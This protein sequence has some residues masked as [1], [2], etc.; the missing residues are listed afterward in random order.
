M[1][2]SEIA[3]LQSEGNLYRF[4][5]HHTLLHDYNYS[6]NMK[7]IFT[8]CLLLTACNLHAQSINDYFQKIRN[9]AA[10]LTAFISQMPKGGDLHNHYS[11]AIYAESYLARVIDKDYCI[12]PQTLEIAPPS[13][14]G[15]CNQGWTKF[16]ILKQTGELN[17][18]KQKLIQYWSIKDYDQVHKDA[19]GQH[20]FATFGNF[21]IPS[22]MNYDSGLAELKKRA[23]S[24]NVSYIET[25]YRRVDLQAPDDSV[26]IADN[27]DT[28]KYYIS[29]L[30]DIQKRQDKL[31]LKRLLDVLYSKIMHLPVIESVDSFNHALDSLH[32]LLRIDDS[33]FTM[34]Y[35][36]Y[37]L[38]TQ[39][40]LTVFKNLIVSF[41][42]VKRDSVLVGVNIVAPEDDEISM[43]DY[44]LHIQ[45]FA[46]C[47]EKCP[48]VNYSMHAGE[49]TEGFVQPEQLTWHI[50]AAVYDAGAQRIGH[51]VDIAYE[52]DNYK[53]L[54]YMNK[55][56]IPVE[57]NLSSNE[58][59]LG[60]KDDKHPVLLYKHFHVPIVISTDDP[61]VSRSSLTE[62]YVLL[63]MRYK[64]ITYDDIKSYV[65][66][67]ITYSFIKDLQK[68]QELKRDL[69][70]R[71]KRFES[72]IMSQKP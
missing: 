72:Y 26:D 24:E 32:Y 13:V 42:A 70:A 17:N 25:M 3:V 7:Q 52:K 19:P 1:N 51:G 28:I 48:E 39:D 12:N 60:V 68:K 20:F 59:I 16:S 15:N 21:S 35:Q 69:D 46:Y 67:S 65:Y 41:E 38:R 8:L 37:I 63:A 56:H 27:A 55:K 44:W 57:I 29:K 14:Y 40:P 31:A 11:G 54:N 62:Q 36:T 64:E 50:S 58:F 2:L 5:N 9:N 23:E 49:L 45:M 4:V 18:Y 71:F 33:V 43:R 6:L 30:N 53:L 61:G 34:R 47:H 22:G 66:N 10:E